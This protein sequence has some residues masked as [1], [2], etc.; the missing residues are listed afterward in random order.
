MKKEAADGRSG[1][2]K[3]AAIDWEMAGKE[4]RVGLTVTRLVLLIACVQSHYV[5]LLRYID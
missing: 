3:G 5:E 1:A 4:S 2:G